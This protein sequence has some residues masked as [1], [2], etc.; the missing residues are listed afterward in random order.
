MLDISDLE[1][2]T[3]FLTLKNIKTFF[4]SCSEAFGRITQC[5]S[6][7]GVYITSCRSLN[8]IFFLIPLFCFTFQ[9]SFFN[10]VLCEHGIIHAPSACWLDKEKHF[11]ILPHPLLSVWAFWCNSPNTMS[12]IRFCSHCSHVVYL[13]E[14]NKFSFFLSLLPV[15]S[16]HRSPLVSVYSTWLW[17]HRES[18]EWRQLVSLAHGK[19]RNRAIDI[20]Y[21]RFPF[22][23]QTNNKSAHADSWIF[24]CTIGKWSVKYMCV[25][26]VY[27][28]DLFSVG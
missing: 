9:C 26:E 17:Y 28:L 10:S 14:K 16:S 4:S 19:F 2:E 1:T 6:S 7:V 27:L 8:F 22:S 18:A 11:I 12:E 23:C 13:T 20:S 24:Q 25:G 21:Y 5:P 15:Q 3:L